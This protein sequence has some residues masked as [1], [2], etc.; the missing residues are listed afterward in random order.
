MDRPSRAATGLRL[1]GSL[2]AAALLLAG[3]HGRAEN[4]MVEAAVK[5]TY[6]YKFGPYVEWPEAALPAEG[7]PALLCIVGTD[8]FGSLLADAVVGESLAGH[9]IAVRRLAT[10]AQARDCMIA[11]I[12]GSEDEPVAAGL[13][14]LRGAPVLTVT[15][16][17]NDTEARGMIHFVVVEDNVRFTIDDHA[18]W[19]SGIAFSSKVLEL[20]LSVTRRPG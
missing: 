17:S 16:D 10:A 12:A 5:A 2:I 3:L 4:P 6:L 13:A 9:P 18:A 19:Q 8:A 14:A 15:D 20:A 1:L 11:F 7:E